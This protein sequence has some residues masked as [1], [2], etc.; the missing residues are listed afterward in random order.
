MRAVDA[1]APSGPSLAS[2][3]QPH[4]RGKH[5]HQLEADPATNVRQHRAH[6]EQVAIRRQQEAL[7]DQRVRGL[8][9]GLYVFLMIPVQDGDGCGGLAE[10]RAS[11]S[12]T[13]WKV[14]G[15]HVSI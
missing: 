10:R 9:D 2:L 11:R 13:P 4:E 8:R 1:A 3:V 5:E 12:L 7:R 6:D 14:P 15:S